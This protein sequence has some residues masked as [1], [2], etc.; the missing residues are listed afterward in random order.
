MPCVDDHLCGLFIQWNYLPLRYLS[1]IIH[2]LRHAVV[3]LDRHISDEELSCR[4]D[5]TD[6]LSCVIVSLVI[7]IGQGNWPDDN[8]S[9]LVCHQVKR[10]TG[11]I[12]KT[13]LQYVIR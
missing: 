5:A 4:L 7:S 2:L 3:I 9:P 8:R 1:D 6:L 13:H 10:S 12:A 11:L